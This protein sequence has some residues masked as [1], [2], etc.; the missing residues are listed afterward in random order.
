MIYTNIRRNL[1]R[2]VIYHWRI[3]NII[4]LSLYIDLLLLYKCFC[5][6]N[7]GVIKF[8]GYWWCVCFSFM[9][10]SLIQQLKFYLYDPGIS[11]I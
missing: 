2:S 11:L 8:I 7:Y 5:D 4:L 6:I 1:K 9:G 3:K 10:T